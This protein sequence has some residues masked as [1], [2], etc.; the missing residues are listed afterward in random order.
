MLLDRSVSRVTDYIGRSTDANLLLD[1]PVHSIEYSIHGASLRGSGGRQIRCGKVIITVPILALQRDDILFKPP[2][3]PEKRSA[4]ERIQM[5]NAVKVST[6]IL[7][8]KFGRQI[9]HTIFVQIVPTNKK[10]H[11]EVN[12]L[13]SS[14]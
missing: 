9:E 5:S 11:D 13:D 8:L 12:A 7:A 10:C 3:P 2:L 6:S 1:W 14:V 4:I